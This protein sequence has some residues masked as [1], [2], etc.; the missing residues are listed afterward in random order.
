MKIYTLYLDRI[1]KVFVCAL[2]LAVVFSI[3]SI[4]A[5]TAEISDAE[6]IIQNG[7]LNMSQSIDISE[8]GLTAGELSFVLN[9]ILKRNP[10]MF[11]VGGSF[12]FSKYTSGHIITI[13]PSYT[14]D[15][16]QRAE[17]DEFIYKEIEKILFYMPWGLDDF[18]KALYFHDYI[19]THFEYDDSLA[20]GNIYSMLKDKKGTCQGY[21]YLYSALLSAAG[22]E[23][24]F[25]YS[26]KIMH[27][28]NLVKID[29]EWYHVDITWNDTEKVF[30]YASHKNFLCSDQEIEGLGHI[31]ISKFENTVCDSEKYSGEYLDY[32]NTSFAYLDGNWYVADNSPQVRGIVKFDFT[33]QN[34]ERI[35]DIIGYWE[36]EENR[37]YAN[38][39]SSV[40]CVG[41]YIYLNFKNKLLRFD[42]NDLE[43]IYVSQNGEQLCYAVAFGSEIYMSVLDS[44]KTVKVEISPDGDVNGDREINICDIVELSLSIEKDIDIKNPFGADASNDE[45]LTIDDVKILRKI[46][47]CSPD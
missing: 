35:L 12:S 7:F 27:I 20:S 8:C 16:A 17:A 32:I 47:L 38:C 15:K 21:A 24:D 44:D 42:G 14:M 23:N 10:Y 13:T 29:G 45:K 33:S 43:E 11:Y 36:M 9:R 37:F 6:D 5:D 25:A 39:F 34:G 28:W 18:G 30:G 31:E 19:C 22:V 41:N 2:M 46:L 26:D 40:A 1:F 4:C 3:G